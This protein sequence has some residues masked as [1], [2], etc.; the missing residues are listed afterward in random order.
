MLG[1]CNNFAYVI[2]LSAA[3]DILSVVEDSK[4]PSKKTDD[5]CQHS[6]VR[7]HCFPISTGSVLLANIIPSL[8]VKI[9]Y[10]FVMYRV[11]FG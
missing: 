9:F 3:E 1:M 5:P 6:V 11:P 2:M 8:I 7:R 10:P 4:A